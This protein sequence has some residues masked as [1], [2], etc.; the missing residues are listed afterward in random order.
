M[1]AWMTQRGCGRSCTVWVFDDVGSNA[2]MWTVRVGV[3]GDLMT[4]SGDV[5]VGTVPTGYWCV[6]TRMIIMSG[7]EQRLHSVDVIK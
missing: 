1:K 3:G 5:R 2:R 6:I 4:V 7:C